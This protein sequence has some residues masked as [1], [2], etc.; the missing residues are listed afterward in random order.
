M[1][2]AYDMYGRYKNAITNLQ[3]SY[4]HLISRIKE[5]ELIDY[6]DLEYQ[7]ALKIRKEVL[8]MGVLI[9]NLA[10]KV[11]NMDGRVGFGVYLGMIGFVRETVG[12]MELLPMKKVE[13][14]KTVNPQKAALEESRAMLRAMMEE[15]MGKRKLEDAEAIKNQ[16]REVETELQE[17]DFS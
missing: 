9:E 16:L 2:K 11:K 4:A 14:Y 13:G 3:P 10:K 6:K 7:S 5:K 8:D 12:R 15:A 1:Q 17:T